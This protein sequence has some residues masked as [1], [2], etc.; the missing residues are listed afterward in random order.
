M[1][2]ESLNEIAELLIKNDINAALKRVYE[3]MNNFKLEE[4]SD[5][6]ESKEG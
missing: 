5:V 6:K 3:L 2:N 1:I 4:T